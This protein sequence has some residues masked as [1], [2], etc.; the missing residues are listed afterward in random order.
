T[1]GSPESDALL[2]NPVFGGYDAGAPGTR[3][4]RT[5]IKTY[6]GDWAAG[7]QWMESTGY[8]VGT[9]RLILLGTEGIRTAVG[10]G[11]FPEADGW[12]EQVALAQMAGL[13]SDWKEAAFWGD[14]D[15][16]RN[17]QIYD[18]YQV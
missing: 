12:F 9:L 5:V 1:A 3:N 18:K 8:D 2:A 10:P 16:P 11:H 4:M 6:V 7:G 15:Q 17:P 13:T 14:N